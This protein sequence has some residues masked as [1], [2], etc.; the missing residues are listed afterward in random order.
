MGARMNDLLPLIPFVLIAFIIGYFVSKGA[1]NKSH[2]NKFYEEQQ[3]CTE[4]A[5]QTLDLMRR[6]V[7][8]LEE[9]A[10]NR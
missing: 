5:K 10:K 4:I 8:A 1:H 9:I 6:Q 3:K 7:A 2:A